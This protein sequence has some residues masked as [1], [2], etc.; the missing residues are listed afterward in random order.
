WISRTPGLVY[1]YE[2]ALGYLVDPA[3]VRD[4]DGISA[5]LRFADLAQRWR[6]EGRTI[7]DVLDGIAA[8]V[9]ASASG[10]VSIRVT[11]LAEFGRLTGELRAAPPTSIA[12]RAVVAADDFLL[13]V[14]GFEP[15]D[16]LRYRLEDGSRVI[17]RPSGTEPKLKVYLDA[18]AHE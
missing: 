7:D 1:G 2:E 16:I 9:G 6:D 13:G 5:A 12:G 8:A 10:Q 18:A 15:A 4:K 11:D 17:V 14:D 3:K